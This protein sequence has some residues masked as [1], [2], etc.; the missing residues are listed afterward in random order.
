VILESVSEIRAIFS[1][2]FLWIDT[3]AFSIFT[4]E[5]LARIYTAPENPEHRER[6]SPRLAYASSGAALID[7]ITILPFI[8]EA[9][10]ANTLDLRFLRVFRLARMLKLTRYTTATSTLLKVVKREW[11]VIFAS[12]FVMMLLVILTASLGYLLEHPAQPDKFE[13]IPQ[14]IYWAVITLASV[15]YGD[16][17]PVTPL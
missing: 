2:H 1:T 15:G 3:I 14:A 11:Q 17:S 6:L 10:W 13:N 5:Y 4:L 8:L 12:V 7:L 9:I 16:I